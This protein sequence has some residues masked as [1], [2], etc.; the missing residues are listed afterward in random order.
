MKSHE[1]SSGA[2]ATASMDQGAR[3]CNTHFAGLYVAHLIDSAR[4]HP[5]NLAKFRTH[6]SRV[7]TL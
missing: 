3:E 2:A 6:L 1:A 5:V 4:V 7:T